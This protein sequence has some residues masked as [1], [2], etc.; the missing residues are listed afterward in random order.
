LPWPWL[1]AAALGRLLLTSWPACGCGPGA[2]VA[3][4]LAVAAWLAAAALGRLLLACRLASGCGPGAAVAGWLAVAGG[5][6]VAGRLAGPSAVAARRLRL[7]AGWPLEARPSAVAARRLRLLAGWPLEARPSAVAARRLRLLAGW[8]LEAR[9]SAVAARRLRLLA[10]SPLASR[11]L[12]A[13][14]PTHAREIYLADRPGGPTAPRTARAPT[15]PRR[16]EGPPP[17]TRGVHHFLLSAGFRTDDEVPGG[18]ENPG[19]KNHLRLIS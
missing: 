10:G 2:A 17:H 11:A 14:C 9:P 5:G 12:P 19:C 8:P 3:G 16:N 4:W 1:A 13:G 6:G 18:V 15:W 7:L